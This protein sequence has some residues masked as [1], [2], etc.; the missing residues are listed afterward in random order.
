MNHNMETLQ[1]LDPFYLATF[2]GARTGPASR[3]ISHGFHA[4]REL[5][6]IRLVS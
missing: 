2:Q 4:C 5:G 3:N 1:I 6:N